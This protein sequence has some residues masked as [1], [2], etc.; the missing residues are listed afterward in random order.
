MVYNNN[1]A[2]KSKK[3]RAGQTLIGK[4]MLAETNSKNTVQKNEDFVYDK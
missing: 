4:H 2:W 1:S 3:G